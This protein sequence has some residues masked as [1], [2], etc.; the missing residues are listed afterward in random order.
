MMLRER[1]AAHWPV[2]DWETTTGSVSEPGS[3][4]QSCSPSDQHDY[5]QPW[6]KLLFPSANRG[7]YCRLK[8]FIKLG[9]S[10]CRNRS[11]PLPRAICPW[12]TL[13]LYWLLWRSGWLEKTC[14]NKHRFVSQLSEERCVTSD[15]GDSGSW[16]GSY[17]YLI[18]LVWLDIW[19][20]FFLNANKVVFP[21][22]CLCA[23]SQVQ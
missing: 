8:L 1:S 22:M 13:S 10:D 12:H 14:V 7:I 17:S 5:L 23:C 16:S 4:R 2:F 18:G 9:G 19:R 20:W 6:L 15:G 11:V 21:T 3:W